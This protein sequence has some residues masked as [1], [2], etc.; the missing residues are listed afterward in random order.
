M[1]KLRLYLTIDVDAEKLGQCR[2]ETIR[3]DNEI[4]EAVATEF[5]WL[6]GSGVKIVGQP[7]VRGK[8][9]VV[10]NRLALASELADR[11][12]RRTFQGQIDDT[13]D[14]EMTCYTEQAQSVFNDLYDA[15]DEM[16]ND[17]D[18]D[19]Q[20]DFERLSVE[21]RREMNDRIKQAEG[22]E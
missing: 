9:I 11:E 22:Q 3:S 4:I 1:D 16:I 10:V 13:S 19:G 14:P 5:D 6:I 18:E 20:S 8:E 17:L 21:E 7:E 2:G 15:F 12:L